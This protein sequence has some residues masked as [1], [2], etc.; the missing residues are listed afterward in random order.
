MSFAFTSYSSV[1]RPTPTMSPNASATPTPTASSVTPTPTPTPSITPTITPTISVTPTPTRTPDVPVIL[2]DPSDYTYNPQPSGDG[3]AVF[4]IKYNANSH[5]VLSWEVSDDN[6]VTWKNIAGSNSETIYLYNLYAE[7]NN[8]L[9][10][11]LLNNGV[12]SIY[13]NSARLSSSAG[14]SASYVTN[15]QITNNNTAEFRIIT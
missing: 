15:T 1:I 8:Y 9:Y 2:N 4:S 7:S 5:V 3:Y 14:D 12:Y 6:G 13:S 10:R 11:C